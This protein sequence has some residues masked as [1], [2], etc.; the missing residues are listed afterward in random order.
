MDFYSEKNI[1][2]FMGTGTPGYQQRRYSE[3]AKAETWTRN[4][5]VINWV[6]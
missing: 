3:D 2:F 5:L 6:L 1:F 4:L